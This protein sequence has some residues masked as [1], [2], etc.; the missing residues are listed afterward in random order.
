[1]AIGTFGEWINVGR[2]QRARLPPPVAVGGIL[3]VPLLLKSS[4]K[5]R[6]CL[7]LRRRQFLGS[8]SPSGHVF[9]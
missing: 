4:R 8:S 3:W 1:M 7:F 2:E 9:K 5:S 6:H